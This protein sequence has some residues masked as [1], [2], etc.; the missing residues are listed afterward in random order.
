MPEVPI[1]FPATGPPEGWAAFGLVGPAFFIRGLWVR[2]LRVLGSFP[3][4]LGSERVRTWIIDHLQ[5]RNNSSIL[6]YL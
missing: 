2:F 3:L 6:A 4:F 5:N 1:A